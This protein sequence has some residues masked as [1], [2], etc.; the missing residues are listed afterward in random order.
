MSW[1]KPLQ[2]FDKVI[3][4]YEGRQIYFGRTQEAKDFFI[5]M[6][7]QCP[8]RQTTADFLSSLTSP[9]ERAVRPGFEDK[10]PRTA[11]E[12]SAAWKS[13]VEYAQLMVDIEDYN[14]E[15]PVGGKSVQTFE[16]SRRVQQ[17]R[18]Q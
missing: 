3:L 16:K 10:I 13:S 5:T 12:F 9:L 14:D 1:S 6:G 15:F 7:F 11:D 2:I 8:E 4:L 18:R 17:A